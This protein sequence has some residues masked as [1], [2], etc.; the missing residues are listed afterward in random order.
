MRQVPAILVL[1]FL[2]FVAAADTVFPAETTDFFS[3][4][5][6]YRLRVEPQP[7]ELLVILA[8]KTRGEYVRLW[9]ASQRMATFPTHGLIAADGSFSVLLCGYVS[10]VRTGR[11]VVVLGPDGALVRTIA[12]T[13]LFQPEEIS[14]ISTATG[15]TWLRSAS[16]TIHPKPVLHVSVGGFPRPSPSPGVIV[17]RNLALLFQIPLPSGSITRKLSVA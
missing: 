13:D 16:L 17:P 10:Q 3:P 12:L 9:S 2:A 5:L 15:Y 6:E 8:R 11:V 14:G 7:E 1:L 4:G